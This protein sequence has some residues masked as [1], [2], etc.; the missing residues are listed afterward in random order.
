MCDLA[1]RVAGRQLDPRP[2]LLVNPGLEQITLKPAGGAWRPG[3]E[4]PFEALSLVPPGPEL[5]L[6]RPVTAATAWLGAG[7]VSV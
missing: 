2:A 5:A 3:Y 4:A 7:A 1:A 6:N